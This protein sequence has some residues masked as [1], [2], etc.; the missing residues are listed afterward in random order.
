[1]D[2]VCAVWWESERDT[3]YKSSLA[4]PTNLSKRGPS[5]FHWRTVR[6]WRNLIHTRLELPLFNFSHQLR[7]VR[8][9]W[10]TFRDLLSRQPIGVSE[11][12]RCIW[13]TVRGPWA[14]SPRCNFLLIRASGEKLHEWRTIRLL[15]ADRPRYQISDS[16]EFF[17]LSQFQL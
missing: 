5:A 3:H 4:D 9:L 16:P 17:Q 11:A 6:L 14:D 15:H 1:M 10:R 12:Y 8:D 7:T 2:E 13:R